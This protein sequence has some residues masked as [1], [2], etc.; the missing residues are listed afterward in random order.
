MATS[1][2]K[3]RQ[4]VLKPRGSPDIAITLEP[5]LKTFD[6]LGFTFVCGKSRRGRFLLK[7]RSRRDRM[8][9]KLKDVSNELRCRMHQSIPEQGDWLKQVV[10][11]YF[12]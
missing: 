4:R 8:K 7:R 10:T 11:G 1:L 6:F 2:A 12:V 9:A 3:R 5:L